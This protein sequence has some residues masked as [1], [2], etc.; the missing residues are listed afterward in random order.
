MKIYILQETNEL[1][2]VTRNILECVEFWNRSHK[3]I[4]AKNLSGE[5][6]TKKTNEFAKISQYDDWLLEMIRTDCKTFC[7]QDYSERGLFV[8]NIKFETGRTRS[9]VWVHQDD[10]R[11]LMLF[12]K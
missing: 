8:E 10:K 2:Y 5:L 9:H 3:E 4:H 7:N 6:G 11:V 1:N 12:V